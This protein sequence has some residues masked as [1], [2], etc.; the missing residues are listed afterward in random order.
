MSAYESDDSVSSYEFFRADWAHAIIAIKKTQSFRMV[1]DAS[2][3]VMKLIA[4][5]QWDNAEHFET[6]RKRAYMRPTMQ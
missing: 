3:K 2:E 4:M 6:I 5:G 1:T